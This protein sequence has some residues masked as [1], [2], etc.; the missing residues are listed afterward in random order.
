MVG[1]SQDTVKYKYYITEI[2]N[3]DAESDYY[4]ITREEV[5]HFFSENGLL[6]NT[7]E[8]D[9]YIKITLEKL[10][11]DTVIE[12][13]TEQAIPSEITP[14]FN[15]TVRDKSGKK[16]FDKVFENYQIYYVGSNI[17]INLQNRYNAFRQA[18]KD[19]LLDFRYDFESQA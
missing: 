3:K 13:S 12:S 17:S 15:I 2:I 11:T 10:K 5:Y 18:L 1:V 9:Y 8:A 14:V 4:S 7:D 16:V 6:K 19:T